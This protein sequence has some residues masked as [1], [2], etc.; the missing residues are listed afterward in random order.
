MTKEVKFCAD[1]V[2]SSKSAY[3][4][5]LRCKDPLVNSDDEYALASERGEAYG[6]SCSTE[7]ARN[8]LFA[9]CGKRGKRWRMRQP[10]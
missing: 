9:K 3:S 10:D 8:S 1:C 6:S 7:R 5:D 2:W 4:Y